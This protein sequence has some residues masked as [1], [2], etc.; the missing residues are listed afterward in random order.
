VVAVERHGYKGKPSAVMSGCG[1]RCTDKARP[2][3]PGARPHKQRQARLSLRVVNV[4]DGRSIHDKKFQTHF[5]VGL[6]DKG[7]LITKG[8]YSLQRGACATPIAVVGGDFNFYIV[9]LNDDGTPVKGSIINSVGT[10]TPELMANTRSLCADPLSNCHR[11]PMAAAE[12]VPFQERRLN[13]ALEALRRAQDTM[14]RESAGAGLKKLTQLR[15]AVQLAQDEVKALTSAVG[16]RLITG[17][18]GELGEQPEKGLPQALCSRDYKG[19]ANRFEIVNRD[20]NMCTFDTGTSTPATRFEFQ[21][22]TASERITNIVVNLRN[23]I[24]FDAVVLMPS[25]GPYVEPGD[26]VSEP[27]YSFFFPRNRNRE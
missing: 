6:V 10:P 11:T 13:A 19:G 25:L 5:A 8:W 9:A 1:R 24:N 26:V 16:P 14:A 3:P 7:T 21:K 17:P 18:S 4:C 12:A 20:D 23:G 22:F 2:Q 27:E 15:K